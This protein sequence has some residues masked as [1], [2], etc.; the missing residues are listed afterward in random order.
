MFV[1]ACRPKLVVPPGSKLKISRILRAFSP[2]SGLMAKE[3]LCAQRGIKWKTQCPRC[4]IEA[5][6][7]TGCGPTHFS[8]ALVP[9]R[10]PNE[11]PNLS[12]PAHMFEEPLPMKCG[13]VAHR[14]QGGLK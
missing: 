10:A 2:A 6:S 11:N 1:P 7:G 3:V 9:R 4:K 8:Y 5:N 13:R 12:H 14:P